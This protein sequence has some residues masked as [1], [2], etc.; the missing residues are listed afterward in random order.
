MA[1][2]TRSSVPDIAEMLDYFRGI[3][4]GCW[5]YRWQGI[6]LAWVI[7]ALGWLLVML[8]PDVYRASTRVYVDTQ[9]SLRPLL[10]GLAVNNDVLSD[11]GLMQRAILSRPN[12]ERLARD[13]DM[14]IQARDQAAFE[15]LINQLQSSIELMRDGNNIIEIGYQNRDA[16]RALTVVTALLN[17][18]IEGSLGENRTD[19]T[20]AE[21]FLVE[22]LSDY[23]GRLNE[24]EANL[25]E[26]KRRNVGVMPEEGADYYARL[27]QES[28]K[29]EMID[30]K[31]RVARNRRAEIERQLE[32]EEPVFG[33]VPADD[34]AGLATSAEDRQITQFEQKLAELRLRY[35]DT[36]PEVI[37]ITKTLEELRAQKE[38]AAAKAAGPARRAYSPLDL[39]PVYQQMKLQ[40]SQVDVDI[41]Q[42]QAEYADQSGV[43]GGL[44]RKVNTI[45]A[46][47]AELTRLM[48]DYD[49]TK[50]QYDQMLRRVETAR[51]S[52]AAEQSK[53]D[54]TFRIIDPPTVPALPV[55]PNRPLLITIVLLF[56]LAAGGALAL[57]LNLL[58]P[59]F[60]TARELEGR[61]GVAVVG[62]LRLVRT[63]PEMAVVRRKSTLV[64]ASIGALVACYGLLVVFG[65]A[66]P[67][68]WGA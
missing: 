11:V 31:L 4:W 18:L 38:A 35:T 16:R 24:A 44:R 10:E 55:A 66:S 6:A 46:I 42:L 33:L 19:S 5:R 68:G 63:E 62:T 40:L 34:K 61:F 43:V 13:A 21:K 23:E 27:Q 56:A 14:D 37:Q 58:Q 52:E 20:A 8:I 22:K 60:Y 9:S 12:L 57:A 47:E 29:L 15:K 1:T 64:L 54:I 50:T 51:L 28:A 48:R 25:A 17:N 59:V 30:G 32:G 3:L 41:A 45:P 7:C 39:N 49:V 65:I 2:S 53:D 67:K 26:F 36:H